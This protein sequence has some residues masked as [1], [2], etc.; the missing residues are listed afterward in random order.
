M[1]T[2][3]FRGPINSLF[4]LGATALLL[5]CGKAT[6]EP[7][8]ADTGGAGGS[9]NGGTAGS[10][11]G[12]SGTAGGGGSS[13][14]TSCL[15][16]NPAGCLQN[17]CN[18]DQACDAPSGE[19]FPAECTCDNGEWNCIGRNCGEYTA[20]PACVDAQYYVRIGYVQGQEATADFCVA[21]QDDSG[22]MPFWEPVGLMEANG[23]QPE[24]FEGLDKLSRYLPLKQKPLYFTKA[25]SS[26]AL[27]GPAINTAGDGHY[28]T[29]LSV[30][31]S[32]EADQMWVIPEM[33]PDPLDPGFGGSQIRIQ[34]ATFR[35]DNIEVSAHVAD[36]PAQ[37]LGSY[38]FGNPKDPFINADMS[39]LEY[40]VV[41]DGAPSG[42]ELSWIGWD[43]LPLY[44]TTVFISGDRDVGYRGLGCIGS[45]PVIEGS[46][47]SNCY[48]VDQL[49]N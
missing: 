13:G 34:N 48:F 40:L 39:H 42:V 47:Y 11:A 24:Q 21:Y 43:L 35:A 20:V 15:T 33:D 38:V 14:S 17:G 37:V 2:T 3:Y 10:N 45:N 46:D 44:H 28:F 26:C 49:G 6:L 25:S 36:G 12:S 31:Y 41:N 18:S 22:E 30:P 7:V 27:G 5:A 19:C 8:G 9:G 23:Y 29:F 4:A 32:H 1:T 16:P